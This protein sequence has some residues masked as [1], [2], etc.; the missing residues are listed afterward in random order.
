MKLGTKFSWLAYLV[1]VTLVLSSC[2]GLK[3]TPGTGGSGGGTG[4]TGG[5][6]GGTGGTGTGS[7]GPFTIGGSALGLQGTGLVLEDNGGDDLTITGAG[8]VPFTFKTTIASGGTYNVIIKTQPSSP[9]QTCSVTNATGTPTA[10]VTNIQVVCAPIFP[11]GGSVSGLLGTGLTLQDNGGDNLVVSGTGNVNFTFA[12]P[13][14]SGGTYAVT[15]LTQ[16]KTPVQT[17]SVVNGSGTVNGNITNVNIICSQPGFSIGGSV[18]GLVTGTGD[19]LELLNNAG[20]DLFV[21]GDTTFTFATPVTAG[22]IYRVSMFLPPNSQLQPCNMFAYTGIASGNVSSVL[23]D[24]EHN[25]WDWISS[26]IPT[27]NAAQQYA[28]VT[29]PLLSPGALPPP[30]VGTP[31][32]R[33]LAVSWTDNAGRK[34]LFGGKGMPFPSPFGKQLPG[35]LLNDLWVFNGTWEPANLPMFINK[36]GDWVVDP[37]PLEVTDASGVYGTL[38]TATAGAAPGARWGASSWTDASG[39]LWMFGGQGDV[40]SVQDRVLLNDI[41]EWVPGGYDTHTG[42]AIAGTFTGQWIWQGGSS[43]GN[44]NGVYGT[45][46]TAAAGNIPGSRWAAATVTDATNNVWLFGG[47]GYDTAGNVGLLND[48]WEYNLTS[49]Q[50]T[51]IGPSPS[52]AF[53]QKGSYG[54]LGTGSATTAP[55]GRENAVLWADASGNIWLFGG[56]GLDSA[57]TNLPEGAVLNDLWEYNVTTKQWVWIS[58][59]GTTGIANQSG[60]YGTQT[61][62]AAANVPGS[63]WGGVGWSDSSSNLWFFGGWGYGSSASQ[64]TGFL[65]DIWEYQHSSGQWIWWK[66]SSGVN[67]NGTYIDTQGVPY[68]NNVVGARRGAAIWQ[69]DPQG[70]VWV[71]GGEGYDSTAGAAP[72]YLNDLWNYLPFP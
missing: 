69:Q 24:C 7:T 37:T 60:T 57:G 15:I 8:T 43:A 27:T 68:V 1:L 67:Q 28:T 44:Q 32:G 62:A 50:W 46:G 56:F 48:L 14:L 4:G 47:Q 54:T 49:K 26:Y 31:G 59:G 41:W 52:N 66:G 65:N 34:W 30:N 36:A 51:W 63:R 5:G 17:C 39:N 64:G 29:T 2:S 71:F 22:G 25:D 11:V 42:G 3:S 19:T 21:T 23:V 61:A 72:G 10:N 9:T 16:P 40:V 38:G 12:T 45:Q 13:L 35:G 58:G 33:D 55:G 53:N 6:T 20:D 18:V 70:F